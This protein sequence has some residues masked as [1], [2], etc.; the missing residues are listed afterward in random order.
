MGKRKRV[1]VLTTGGDCS[2]LNST[3][4]SLIRACEVRNW[5][6]V[7][8]MNGTD[9]FITGENIPLNRETFPYSAINMAGSFIG[10]VVYKDVCARKEMT[11]DGS[12][13][14]PVYFKLKEGIAKIKADCVVMIGGNGSVSWLHSAPELFAGMQT[15]YIPKTIDMD[16]PMTKNTVG[17]NTA[18]NQLSLYI[19]GIAQSAR[20]HRRWFVVK[21]MGRN[22]GHLA[23]RGG[24]AAGA[25]AIILPEID[26]QLRDLVSFVKGTGRSFGIIV[27]A[28][29]SD[30][31]VEEIAAALEGA[32]FQGRACNADYFQRGG[33]SVASDRLLAAEFATAALD[34]LDRGETMV[35]VRRDETS[36]ITTVGID[37]LYDA[38]ITTNDPNVS[39]MTVTYD[40][41]SEDDPFLKAARGLGVF[42]G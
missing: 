37:E 10:S 41:V 36:E 22:S 4:F 25:D 23:L 34:A 21:A 20:S 15:V 42:L 8:I 19:D 2:G 33:I 35:M 39:N 5:E 13:T 24:M 38:G 32:G 40:V 31:K 29:G 11:W 27:V 26:V 18:V 28:E 16:V 17:F 1:A 3:L 6:L 12:K 9:G 30:L 7:G 14:T